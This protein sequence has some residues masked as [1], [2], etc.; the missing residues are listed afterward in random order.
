VVQNTWY[1]IEKVT[2]GARW[3]YFLPIMTFGDIGPIYRTN[4]DGEAWGREDADG[5]ILAAEVKSAMGH[6]GWSEHNFFPGSYNTMKK[7]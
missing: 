1:T 6:N 4:T 2:E 3:D 5:P 7:K